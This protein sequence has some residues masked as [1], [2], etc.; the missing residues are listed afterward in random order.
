MLLEN[1]FVSFY[2]P[3]IAKPAPKAAEADDAGRSRRSRFKIDA[4]HESMNNH[5][6]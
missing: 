4:E 1:L 2:S 5:V 6:K 3:G